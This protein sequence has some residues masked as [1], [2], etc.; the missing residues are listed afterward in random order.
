MRP[1][2]L[3]LCALSVLQGCGSTTTLGPATDPGWDR[4]NDLGA[5]HAADV[6][7]HNGNYWLNA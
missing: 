1:F 5:S 7:L 4:L 2:L 3:A 6:R